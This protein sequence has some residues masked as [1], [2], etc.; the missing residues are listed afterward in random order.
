MDDNSIAF[1][2]ESYP[3]DWATL[4]ESTEEMRGHVSSTGLCVSK[5]AMDE[6]YELFLQTKQESEEYMG[7]ELCKVPDPRG[8]S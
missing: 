8:S 4:L 3:T 7:T 6:F 2:A 5:V 1:S